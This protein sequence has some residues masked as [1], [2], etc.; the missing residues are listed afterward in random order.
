MP[1]IFSETGA[2]CNTIDRSYY[3]M[4][5]HQGIRLEYIPGLVG[6]LEV[7]L[8][9]KHSL[10]VQGDNVQMHFGTDMGRRGSV[11]EF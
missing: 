8:V 5:R 4:L 2:T 10:H 7:S 6:G 3:E 9:S 1:Q 11:Q